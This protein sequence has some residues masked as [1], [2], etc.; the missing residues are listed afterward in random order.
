VYVASCVAKVLLFSMVVCSMG[1]WI[2]PAVAAE[3]I[4]CIDHG[5]ITFAGQEL[6]A[7]QCGDRVL[8]SDATEMKV[9]NGYVLIR[10][11][12]AFHFYSP[13]MDNLLDI[14][15]LERVAIGQEMP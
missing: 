1:T 13:T 15:V 10:L 4:E 7:A 3:E 6:G 9:P 11:G 5:A 2:V 12:N 8:F 14:N